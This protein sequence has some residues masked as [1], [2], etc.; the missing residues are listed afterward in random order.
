MRQP[1]KTQPASQAAKP[2]AK[3]KHLRSGTFAEHIAE[4]RRRLVVIA[5]VFAVGSCLAYSYHEAL[6]KIIMAPLHGQKLVYLTPG[7][8]FSFIFQITLYAGLLLAA[9]FIIYHLYAFIRPALPLQ[10]RRSAGRVVLAAIGLLSLG[11][12]YGYFVAVPAALHFLAGFAGDTITP[13][14]TADSYL[15]FFLSYIGGLALLSLLP[16]LLIFW[17]WINPLTPGGLLKSERWVIVL[18]FVAAAIIT[19]TPDA[20]N[21][22]MIAGPVILLYQF[23]VAAVLISIQRQ[24]RAQRQ[25]ARHTDKQIE[26]EQKLDELASAWPLEVEA[27]QQQRPRLANTTVSTSY[28][29]TSAA[30]TAHQLDIARPTRPAVIQSVQSFNAATRPAQNGKIPI[31]RGSMDIL[32]RPVHREIHRSDSRQQMAAAIVHPPVRGQS[33]QPS[34]SKPQFSLDGIFHPQAMPAEATA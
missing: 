12:A 8:G 32:P 5:L 10:A 34:A 28:P 2:R 24:K 15:S 19:P 7:G 14:L 33:I 9:P 20:A 13:N 3:A 27:L 4:L 22:A 6:A 26:E 23:G 29:T 30:K 21:Q 25:A 11:I 17:H 18:A 31:K 1:T 16:L